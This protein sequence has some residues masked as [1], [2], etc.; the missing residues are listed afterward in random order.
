M[1]VSLATIPEEEEHRPPVRPVFGS[2]WLGLVECYT[3]MYGM[4]E[5]GNRSMQRNESHICNFLTSFSKGYKRSWYVTVCS[6]LRDV[7]MTDVFSRRNRLKRGY[8]SCLSKKHLSVSHFE[9]KLQPLFLLLLSC[10]LRPETPEPSFRFPKPPKM[11]KV[12]H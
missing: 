4:L 5:R 8:W 7:I 10:V 11:H 2:N 9:E 1:L 6:F 12:W 3:A